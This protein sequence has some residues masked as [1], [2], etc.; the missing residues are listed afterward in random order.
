[1]KKFGAISVIFSRTEHDNGPWEM[2]PSIIDIKTTTIEIA[3]PRSTD[4]THTDYSV[5]NL[6][7]LNQIWIVI[8]LFR[9]N[10][11][12]N[13]TFSTDLATNGIPFGAISIIKE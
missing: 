11:D 1:M 8:T 2:A 9:P 4:L 5:S 10:L 13:Y 12:C 7:E 6:F 3:L